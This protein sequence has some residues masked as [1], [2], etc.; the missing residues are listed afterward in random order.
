MR[1]QQTPHT[2]GASR[3][4]RHPHKP[5]DSMMLDERAQQTEDLGLVLV[6]PPAPL[7]SPES[8]PVRGVG[9]L[10][11]PRCPVVPPCYL[12]RFLLLSIPGSLFLAS[13]GE[14]PKFDGMPRTLG[15][16]FLTNQNN[17]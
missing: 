4:E 13:A 7:L 1:G 3:W 2:G 9:R 5:K 16:F 12:D 14:A 10:S 17:L 8:P 6:A 11:L 15:C